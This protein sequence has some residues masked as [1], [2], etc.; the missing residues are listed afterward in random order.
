M[1]N[2]SELAPLVEEIKKLAAKIDEQ[3]QKVSNLEAKQRF[4]EEEVTP[5][6]Q[7]RAIQV[8]RAKEEDIKL[9]D[10]P[11]FDGE[12]DAEAYLDWERRVERFFEHRNLDDATRFSKAI[13]KLSK[14]ASSV[15]ENIQTQR[16]S[17]GKHR[18]ST[19]TEL[20]AK[21]KKKFVPRTYRQDLYN[22]YQNLQQHD[23]DVRGYIK[24]F[25]RLSLACNAKEEE[26]QRMAKFVA[27]LNPSIRNTVELQQMYTLDDAY[28]IA[29]KVEKQQIEAKSKSARPN[30]FSKIEA[31][32]AEEPKF[33]QKLEEAA[34]SIPSKDVKGGKPPTLTPNQASMK[35]KRC[36]KCQGT[37]HIQSQCPNRVM[38]SLEDHLAL[39]NTLVYEKKAEPIADSGIVVDYNKLQYEEIIEP[40]PDKDTLLLRMVP[41]MDHSSEGNRVQR[42]NLFRSRCQVQ[43]RSCSL[44]I[45]GGSSTN[46]ASQKMVDELKL[47]PKPHPKPYAISWISEH[48]KFMV[49]DQV[50]V[51]FSIGNFQSEAWCDVLPMTACSLLLGRPW[52]WDNNAIHLCK[53]NIYTVDYGGKRVALK[54]LPPN[55]V[56]EQHKE[57]VPA[58]T[59][60][61]TSSYVDLFQAKGQNKKGHKR[62]GGE[63]NLAII[64]EAKFEV[65]DYVWL[66]LDAKKLDSKLQGKSK[67]LEEG[68]FK[69]VHR[70]G[71]E[72][73]QVLLGEGMCATFNKGDLIPCFD[74]T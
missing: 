67:E 49:K 53:D 60:S 35:D 34:S 71:Y 43:S 41:H 12:L 31:N 8:I 73:Y 70:E 58:M 23:M 45:D 52:Q 51:V 2:Q 20:K 1:V 54:P 74:N 48:G 7:S 44:I 9:Q 5:T 24:E 64:Q 72:T 18:I 50:L 27:G 32:K 40:E 42:R 26:E 56:H 69:V 59:V 17:E 36:F 15:Y 55:F 14:H 28:S 33:W 19:W 47:V 65:G 29:S 22:R 66:A 62:Q 63:E 11:E 6:P 25:E 68:P 21:L 38:V 37:G 61:T 4:Y 10:L 3:G 30:F 39:L 57:G 46:V 16:E 13:L